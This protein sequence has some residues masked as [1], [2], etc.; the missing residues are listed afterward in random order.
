[1]SALA[2]PRDGLAALA[3]VVD[4][5]VDERVGIVR[6]VFEVHLQPGSP[7]FFHVFA[8]ASNTG[9]F[10]RQENFVNT[11]GAASDRGRA[12]AKAVGEAV[13]RYCSAIYDVDELPLFAYRDAPGPAV[14]PGELA[15]YS[16]EQYESPGFPWVPFGIDTPVRW[17]PALDLTT[18]ATTFVPACRVFMPYHYYLGTG[19]APIDQPISTGMACHLSHA[20]AAVAAICEVVERDAFTICWQAMLA[21]PQIRLDTLDDENYD[22]V[23][24][25]ERTAGQVTIFDVTLDHGIPTVLSVLRGEP[26]NAAAYVFAAAC[27]PDP[28][29]AVRKSLEELAHTRR[30]AQ[31]LTDHGKGVVPAS[32]QHEVMYQDQH[33]SFAADHAN[34]AAFDF[35]YASADR[36]VLDAMPN[37]SRAD[38][39]DEVAVLVDSVRSV[40]E[41]VLIA[42]LTTSDIRELGMAVVRAVVPG[43]H[44]LHM[45]YRLRAL[46]GRRLWDVPRR[47]GYPG[48]TA[49]SGDNP[50]PHPYP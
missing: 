32:C 36:V 3:D 20:S 33:L 50:T 9:S 11:G 48:V 40:G 15:L 13:E 22:L 37:L 28:R 1:V 6:S 41:R 34:A 5:L 26:P 17:T 42:D 2:A 25:F 29:D 8:R 35:L 44:P 43:F 19:D 14:A 7:D 30:Y 10:T 45:G 27:A 31:W 49:E 38:P 46:G 16:P 23:Q 21:P 18:G 39:K 24:R 4:R 47:L 12:V